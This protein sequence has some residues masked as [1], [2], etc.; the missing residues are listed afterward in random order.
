MEKISKYKINGYKL[1]E[2][3]TDRTITPSTKLVL[4]NLTSRLGGKNFCFPSQETI[5]KDLGLSVRYVRYHISILRKRNI[6]CTK[7]S[8]FN[9]KTSKAL[10]SNRYDLS[11]ILQKIEEI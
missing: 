5:A 6:I 10:N 9:P 8:A 1:K 3:L 2:I 4:L 11:S 7:R